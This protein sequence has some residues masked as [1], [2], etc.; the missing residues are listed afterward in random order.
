MAAQ[1]RLT[2]FMASN[3][4]TLLDEDGDSSDWIEIQNTTATQVNLLNWALTDRVGNPAQWLFPATNLAPGSFLVVFASGKDRRAPGAPLH[5]NFKLD[6]A[7]EYLAL[8]RPDRTAATELPPAYPAQFPDVSYGLAMQVTTTVLVASN[9]PVLYRIPVSAAEDAGW[10]QPS[11]TSAGWQAG[12]NGLGYET[13]LPDSVAGTYAAKVLATGPVAYWRLNETS[14]TEAV[15][16]GTTGVADDGGYQGAIVLGNRGPRPPSFA[17]FDTNNTAPLFDGTSAYVNGPYELV[18]AL[19]AFTLAGWIN[20]TAGQGNRTGLFGQNDTLEFGFIEPGKIQVWTAYGEVMVDYPFPNNEWHH[21]M[22]VGGN[23]QLALYF[24]GN[25]AGATAASPANFGESEFD[26]NIGGGGVFDPMGNYFQGLIDEVAVWFR[27]LSTNEIATMLG[28]N[29]E[30]VDYS[31]HIATDVRPQ[32]F[33]SNATAYVRI[34]FTIA[35]PGA[36]DSL[37]LQVRYDDGFAAFL[38]GHPIASANAPGALSWDSAATQSH[39]DPAAVQWESFAVSAALPYLQPGSNVL[40]VQGLNLAPTNK[41]FLLQ[42][43]LLAGSV[44]AATDRWRY[45]LT[46]TPGGPNGTGT[47]DLGPIL[48]AAGHWPAVPQ[49]GDSLTVTAQVAQAFHPLS[50]VTLHYRVMFNPEV[51]VSMNDAGTNGD[52]GPGDGIWSATIPGGIAS[53]GRMIRYYVTAA[54]TAGQVSRWPL[55]A[56]PAGWQQYLGTMV[57]DPAVAS[58]LPVVW[59]FMQNPSAA[60]NQTGTPASLFY[61]NE[62][63]DNLAIY[64]HGQVSVGWPKKSHN[65]DFPA[66]HRFLYQPDGVRQKKVIFMSNYGDKARLRTTLTYAMT[67]QGG[68]VAFF[69]FPIRI[70]RNGSFW[71]IADMVEHGDELFLERIGRDGQGALYKMYNDLSSASGNEKK[72]R[73][74]EGTEDLDTLIANL[75]ESITLANRVLYAYDH[76]DLPQT[77]GFFANLALASDQ[78]VGH[79]NYYLYRDSEGTGEWSI[80]PWDVDL[81][82]GRNWV[83]NFTG[84]NYLND[85]SFQTNPLSFYPGAPIQSKPSNRLFDLFFANADFRQMYLRRLRTLMDTILKPPGT[86]ADALVIESLIRQY[87]NAMNPATTAPSDAALD[88]AV[89]GPSWGDVSLSRFP[90]DAERLIA[91]HLAGRRAF[92]FTSGQATL[93]GDPIPPP[94]P[95]NTVVSFGAWDFQPVSG[96]PNEQFI[97]LR[98]TNSYAVDVSNWRLT[99]GVTFS[100]RPGTV[101]PAG[102]SLYLAA[103]VNAFRARPSPPGGRQGL[104]VQGPFAGL[105]GAQGNTPLILE[106]DRGAA[107]SRNPFAGNATSVPFV[108]GNLALLRVGDGSESLSG[109][110]NSVFVDQYTTNGTLVS[111]IPIPDQA[112]NALIVSGSAVSEGALTRTPDGRL[113]VL[114]G[115]Q[116]PLTEAALLGSSLA[117]TEATLVPR[118]VGVVDLDSAFAVAAVTT[119]QYSQNNLRSAASDG[120]GNYWGAGANSGTCYWGNGAAATIQDAV[121]NT[122]VIQD[123]GGDLFFS[124]GKTT[125]GLW[126][127]PGTPTQATSPALI[128]SEQPGANPFAFAF[129]PSFTTAYLADDSLTGEGGV[130]RWDFTAGAWSFTYAFIGLT[131][132]GARGLAVDFTGPHPKIYATSAQATNNQLVSLTDTG[133]ASTVIPLAT[134]GVNQIFRGL[135]FAP[136]GSSAPCFFGGS[137]SASGF[138]LRWTALIDRNYT[139]EYTDNLVGADWLTLTNV[140]AATPVVTTTDPGPAAGG[141]RFY[142]LILN[143]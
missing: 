127:I 57:A 133:P 104:F 142:R 61:R 69:S 10:T 20:P 85:V 99:G 140:T 14:G 26:F 141:S 40:A 130:Q 24:D 94:Q 5:T 102:K 6:S 47:N 90:N 53:P 68:G 67:G 107:V 54:D 33:G 126:R 88:Q 108:A 50:Q 35:D 1:V 11:F 34:P 128:L 55:E 138:E 131:N 66:D 129:N 91:V 86:P 114:A 60:D 136:S 8:F 18:N 52:A 64:V 43:Q 137:P 21:V 80:F 12:T 13:G 132:T 27:A 4:H 19:P 97:E 51:S 44:T 45:F 3:T 122:A 120:A 106:N 56:D 38:N 82:W 73:L 39:P 89:W 65:L 115:Y 100:L 112:A 110:G 83:D 134:A 23:G 32:M 46:P 118:A 121:N 124:T 125:P 78:D 109:H 101:I 75:D 113:L 105:L 98:N 36:F 117:N 96:N 16:S 87:E 72:T 76:L 123:L 42:V 58:Q 41:D 139:L 25:L 135:A 70:E 81:S 79:K 111:T 29:A 62:L 84:S 15:N 74:Q 95:T 48:T 71:G 103:N 93:K 22:A 143:P 28:T 37:R 30:Q 59:L 7:G 119:N 116:I 2:E 92:L 63:Y 31:P 49:A 17:T 77:A 9:A